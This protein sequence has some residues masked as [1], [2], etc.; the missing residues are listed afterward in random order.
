MGG[1][2]FTV[3][4]LV[5]CACSLLAQEPPSAPTPSPLQER[6]VY[7]FRNAVQPLGTSLFATRDALAEA[8]NTSAGKPT[9]AALEQIRSTAPMKYKELAL[10]DREGRPLTRLPA[11]G[12]TG[13]SRIPDYARV[14][15]ETVKTG[16]TY[17]GEDDAP[18][19][20]GRFH[21]L[22]PLPPP[23]TTNATEAGL[24]YACIEPFPL[25]AQS[26]TDAGIQSGERIYFFRTNGELVFQSAESFGGMAD[27]RIRKSSHSLR[28]LFNRALDEPEGTGTYTGFAFARTELATHKIY[29]LLQGF[30]MEKWIIIYDHNL[31][32]TP[33]P[34]DGPLTG[35]WN[36]SAKASPEETTFL[37]YLI[38]EGPFCFLRA[39]GEQHNFTAEAR[40]LNDQLASTRLAQV[41]YPSGNLFNL[42]AT[43]QPDRDQF[44]LNLY[45][46]SPQVDIDQYIM[47]R[48][49][50]VTSEPTAVPAISPPATDF[51]ASE[52]RATASL[53][54]QNAEEDL[55]TVARFIQLHPGNA[56]EDQIYTRM[57]QRYPENISALYLRRADLY[58]KQIPGTQLDAASFARQFEQSMALMEQTN[59]PLILNIA[60]QN[61]SPQLL[62]L[63]PVWSADNRVNGLVGLVIPS[64][65]FIE[66]LS[67]MLPEAFDG[68]LVVVD[69]TGQIIGAPR[70]LIEQDR[71]VTESVKQPNG[72]VQLSDIDPDEGHDIQLIAEWDTLTTGEINWRFIVLRKSTATPAPLPQKLDLQGR[73][74]GQYKVYSDKSQIPTS[75]G[76]I[77]CFISQ[78]GGELEILSSQNQILYKFRGVLDDQTLL[79][80]T[81]S[82]IREDGHSEYMTATLDE[83]G[84]KISGIIYLEDGETMTEHCFTVEASP[85]E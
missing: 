50:N 16:R 56:N 33:S 46:N 43:Y 53:L 72:Q 62:L 69:G 18:E 9:T 44:Q 78:Q 14:V 70:R 74:K 73:W 83:T 1:I 75:Q 31:P 10:L 13:T 82:F 27:I 64:T 58:L 35:V 61:A 41:R 71:L 23:S 28:A 30:M 79:A 15:A 36:V 51:S 6:A 68:E 77:E 54:L 49:V 24:M 4:L 29:W 47:Q 25:F 5:C 11:S 76:L 17:I 7:L 2:E 22:I 81:T 60:Q 84:N 80:W 32:Y 85:D 39:H 3:G 34:N 67:E 48:G 19:E 38:Q 59:E 63:V 52:I 42:A 45:I 66:M 21:V 20:A 26:L 55:K 37:A 8:A 65:N 12:P 40:F 57:L